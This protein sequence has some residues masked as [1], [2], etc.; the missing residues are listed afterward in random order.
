MYIF[1]LIIQLIF[2]LTPIAIYLLMNRYFKEKVF[3]FISAFVFM[4]SISF[5]IDMPAH[6]RQ[7]IAFLFFAL[8]FLVLFNNKINPT[9]R[10]IFFLIFGFSMIV[11]HYSTSYITFALFII[12]YI[13]VF[14][15]KK[16]K[17]RRL[18]NDK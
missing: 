10:K 15:Y 13:L 9:I 12:A 5:T 1:K 3:S 4:S 8:M 2:S 6:I 16:Y 11:S 17:N 18:K 14:F 7:E